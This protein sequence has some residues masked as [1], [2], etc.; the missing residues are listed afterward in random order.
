MT[1][2]EILLW[3]A[4]KDD[5]IDYDS[6]ERDIRAAVIGKD[7]KV[8]IEA[9]KQALFQQRV[10]TRIEEATRWAVWDHDGE[11]VIG[12]MQ[13]PLKQYIEEIICEEKR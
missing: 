2:R 7:I 13:H 1:V 11:Q 5:S 8:G 4:N 9:V 10:A 6:V 3:L 12:V